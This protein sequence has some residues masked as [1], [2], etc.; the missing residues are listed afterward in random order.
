MN[1][2]FGSK[3]EVVLKENLDLAKV[4]EIL[5]DLCDE[6]FNGNNGEDYFVK[7]LDS[8][9]NKILVSALEKTFS[10]ATSKPETF[11]TFASIIKYVLEKNYGNDTY[12]DYNVHVVDTKESIVISISYMDCY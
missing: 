8:N 6:D 2:S 3:N 9:G 1:Y 5:K 11:D 7:D 12:C 10:Y 4:K